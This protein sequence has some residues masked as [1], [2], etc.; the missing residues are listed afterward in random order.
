MQPLLHIFDEFVS[1]HFFENKVALLNLK[2]VYTLCIL[3]DLQN[4]FSIP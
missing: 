1:I 3:Y 2:G 4:D